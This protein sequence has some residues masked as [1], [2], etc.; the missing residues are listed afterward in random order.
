MDYIY[1]INRHVKDLAYKPLDILKAAKGTEIMPDGETCARRLIEV[2]PKL[3]QIESGE[4]VDIRK[5]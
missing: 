1:M 3:L 4:Y 2:F 5:L